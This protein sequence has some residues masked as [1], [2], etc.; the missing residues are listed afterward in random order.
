M[1]TPFDFSGKKVLVT[2]ASRGI[3]L[4]VARGFAQAGADL[5]IIATNDKVHET[6]A[7]LT[8]ATGRE[9]QGLVCD[10]SDRA[11]V[12]DV[13]GGLGR[14]DVLVNNAGY[15]RLTP[16]LDP[17]PETEA[18][19]R[20]IIEINVLGTYYVTREAVIRMQ[21][22]A[23]IVI[24][25]SVWGKTGSAG[26]SAYCA[27]KHANI[28]FMRVLADEL[29]PRGIGVNAVCPGWV[30]DRCGD[31]LACY[32]GPGRAPQRGR[33]PGRHSVRSGLRWT[34]GTRRYGF[35]LPVPCLRACRQY[36]R[37][38]AQ[39]RP[40]GA[41]DLMTLSGKRV[42]VTGAS[43]GIGKAIA[44]AMAAAGATVALAA[45]T[46]AIEAKK[47]IEQAGGE[48]VCYRSDVSDEAQVLQLLDDIVLDLGGVDVV[49]N[50]AGVI[51]EKPLLQTG[52][53]DFDRLM[54]VN[55]RGTFLV[56]REAIRH[57]MGNE[58][59]GRVVNIASDL[60]YLGREQFSV[61]CASKA[62]VIALTKSWAREFAPEIL[63]NSVSPGPVDT[64]MLDVQSMSPEWRKK[65]EDIPL[66]RIAQPEEI[67]GIVVFL[68][69]AGGHVH[70]RAGFWGQ[71]AA[72]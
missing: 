27:S 62:A 26:F 10:I 5:F 54:A 66:R 53:D 46:E 16:I 63:V 69:R 44:Q 15:E 21:S 43:R 20:R 67:A 1:V 2:G 39:C 30:R 40:R 24:T 17:D 51:L 49:V 3:G 18:I 33:M 25:A 32:P 52:A 60:G 38:G 55:L 35:N 71:R 8:Q 11:A 61:Y 58:K 42:L 28:G 22:G 50:N 4:G 12:T 9:V 59:G 65:E 13:V 70:H 48:A 45:R 34:D 68:G 14:L 7:M 31:A 41:H 56:G 47:E 23:R 64:D 57:M 36:Y 29:G 19:F 37:S 72:V 6:A